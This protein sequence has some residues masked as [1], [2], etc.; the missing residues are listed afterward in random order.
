MSARG[1]SGPQGHAMLTGQTLIIEGEPIPVEHRKMPLKDVRL[2]PNNPRIQHAVKQK[3]KN[4]KISD[5]DLRKLI[6][7]QPG[8]SELF[9]SI[10]D[11]GG[12]LEPIYVRPDGRIIEGN[13]RA[14]SYL[15]LHGINKQDKRWQ[16]IPAVF[17]PDIS[18][19]QV[20][21]LQGQ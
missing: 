12:I 10:R 11:N 16:T 5:E 13:C 7:D 4:G 19:R 18:E 8:V 20:A 2:D 15:R 14:A 1:S 17:V 3:S 21:I 9:K 6:L